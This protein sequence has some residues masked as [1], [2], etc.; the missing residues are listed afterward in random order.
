MQH[1]PALFLT[2]FG[3]FLLGGLTGCDKISVVTDY[4]K[5]KVSS[6]KSEK[7]QPVADK[8]VTTKVSPVIPPAEENKEQATTSPVISPEAQSDVLAKVGDWSITLQEF[9]KRLNAL[10]EMAPE[11]NSADVEQNKLILNEVV[12]QQLLAQE[13][14][15]LGLGQKDEVMHAVKEFRQ[16]VLIRA[17]GAQLTEGVAASKEE[18]EEYYNTNKIDFVKPAQWKLRE[19]VVDNEADAKDILIEL[20]KGTDFAQMAQT[21]SKGKTAA[22]GGELEMIS[23]FQSEPLQ[24]AVSG[25]GKGD[26]SHVFKGVDGHTIVKVD[27][28]I[29]GE[30]VEFSEVAEDLQS[31]LTG[32]KQQQKVMQYIEDLRSKASIDINAKLLEE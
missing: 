23:E 13:A 12:N 7:E 8:P 28:K 2:I 26:V 19:I 3:I 20:L 16:T 5:Q 15:R 24:N 17:L 32:L 25:L 31:Q 6:T 11:F 22:Q 9:K 18:A 21:R 10:K 29:G 30:Q 27:D 4:L 14:D 1:R